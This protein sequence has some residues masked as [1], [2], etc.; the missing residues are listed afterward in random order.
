MLVDIVSKNGNL[1]LNIPLKGDG[2]IDSDE[3][4]FLHDM[5]D[6]MNVNGE[7]IFATRPWKVFG[8]GT[9]RVTGG[10]FNEDKLKYTAGDLRFTTKGGKLFVF[11]LGMPE[12]D[13]V[14]H[15]LA[16]GGP[17]SQPAVGVRLLGSKDTVNDKQT[18]D[19]L[20]LPK[21]AA[22]PCKHVLAYEVA[23]K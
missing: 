20:V 17:M 22:L 8:E 4:S 3:R 7:A 9:T 23:F 15:T 13:T 19:G 5:A 1:M 2:S 14:V 21:P 10:N 18:G 12:P 6:W 16:V 11:V